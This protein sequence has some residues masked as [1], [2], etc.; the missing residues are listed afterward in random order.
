MNE[1]VVG[2]D[3]DAHGC[4]GSAGYQWCATTKNCER[5]WELAKVKGFENTAEE[6]KNFC[7]QK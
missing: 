4:I 2:A 1:N 6:F 3:K 5:A 7:K